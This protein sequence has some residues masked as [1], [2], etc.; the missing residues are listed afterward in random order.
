MQCPKLT[1]LPP[2]PLGKTGWP[3]TEETQVSPEQ[4]IRLP[5]RISIVTPSFNTARYLE[6]TIRSVLLQGYPDLE[7]IVIDGCSTDGSIEI[8]KK[9]E[10]W[11]TH[12]ISES[13]EGYAD[14]VNK[15]F[16]LAT[17]E[18]RA[19]MPAS[20]LYVK[21]AL[22]TA[23]KLFSDKSVDMIF[24]RYYF[25]SEEGEVGKLH[26]VVAYKLH[27]I[28][29]YGRGNPCQPSTFWRREIHERT[30]RLNTSLIY[31]ADS[32]WFLRMSLNGKCIGVAE[33][34]CLIRQHS[35]QLSARLDLMI[36][37][38]FRAWNDV[39]RKNKIKR[40][41]ILGGSLIYIPIMRY[42]SG[43]VKALFRL[44]SFS[45]LNRIFFASEAK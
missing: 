17:G 20:D 40:A 6:E 31:A 15:G 16:S 26:P 45:T 12:W 36:Q 24:S 13:D 14:A 42:R 1:E 39:V 19:W 18:I 28:S 35:G 32:E 37:E 38:W 22:I 41:V 2:P 29:L 3:W 10:Q 5:C 21:S 9:Y 11:I 27:H 8:I 43:G 34:I 30:G 44:P 7:Y 25:L 33:E 23:Y 4:S